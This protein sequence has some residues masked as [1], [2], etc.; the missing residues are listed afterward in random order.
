MNRPRMGDDPPMAHLMTLLSGSLLTYVGVT[1]S[2][3]AVAR[4]CEYIARRA[5]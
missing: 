1:R 5:G 3:L 4:G 2:S